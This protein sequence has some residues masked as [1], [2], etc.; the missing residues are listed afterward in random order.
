MHY[1]Y[2]Y[3]QTNALCDCIEPRVSVCMF[4]LPRVHCWGR[5]PQGTAPT[6]RTQRPRLHTET[7]QITRWAT[8]PH[9]I[10][11][12]IW[13]N[14]TDLEYPLERSLLSSFLE[15]W[16]VTSY[17]PIVTTHLSLDIS[18]IYSPY[19]YHCTHISK[20]CCVIELWS[21]MSTK[22]GR[23]QSNTCRDNWR[24]HTTDHNTPPPHWGWG[25]IN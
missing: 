22:F 20:L 15:R 17:T 21:S 5:F 12:E 14:M 9:C 2:K 16:Y 18:K 8:I 1:E 11:T 19:L 7:R 3:I 23:D 6:R 4:D 25:N 24:T 13:Q 10:D